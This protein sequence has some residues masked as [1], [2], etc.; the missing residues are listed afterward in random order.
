M[1][2]QL[3]RMFSD[4]IGRV[5]TRTGAILL[6]LFLG[7][8]FLVQASINTVVLGLFPSEATGDL[9]A[10]LGLTLPV[11]VTVGS[12]LLVASFVLSSAYFVVLSRALTRSRGELSTFPRKIY[13]DRIGRATLSTIGGSV[14]VGLSVTIGLVLF[15]L[16]GLFLGVCFLFFLFAVGVEDRR[17]LDALKRSWALSRGNRLKLALLVILAGVIGA[18]VGIVGT[19]FDLTNAPV[20]AELI[21]NTISSVLFV[22]LYGIVA[23]AYLQA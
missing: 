11:S 20:I 8:Q 9:E 15:V 16:P 19:V 13:T 1:A 22:F 23:A 4:G 12:V 7:I 21:T 3:G 14:V 2:F 18:V 17:A 6:V 5:L 10:V